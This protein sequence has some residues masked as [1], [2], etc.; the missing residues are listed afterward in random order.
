MNRAEKRA[1]NKAYQIANREQIAA[2]RAARRAGHGKRGSQQCS[3]KGCGGVHDARGL[4]SS[5]YMAWVRHGDPE[6]MV[7]TQHHG[8][9]LE[10]RF[11]AY[12]KRGPGC[13]E[14]TSAKNAFG[15]GVLRVGDG[16]T[17]AHRLAWT[18]ARGKIPAGQY[19]L[20]RCDNPGCVRPSHL[21]LGTLADNNADMDAKGRRIN[22]PPRG[23][24][25]GMAKL[26]AAKVRM[27][28]RSKATGAVL[29]QRLNVTQTTISSVRRRHAWRDV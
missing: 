12:V 23:E 3:I 18:F 9:T 15:Y 6:K 13:W 20:H 10:Q 14:W 19:V 24:E 27:I 11:G 16:N 26:T 17:L 8:L 28:R 2:N 7:Q 25:N 5:H 1:Y 29:A 4:C 21:F 22:S